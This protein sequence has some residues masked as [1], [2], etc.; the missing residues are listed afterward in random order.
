MYTEGEMIKMVRSLTTPTNT[1]EDHVAALE[2]IHTILGI[3][4]KPDY[5]RTYNAGHVA[6]VASWIDLM[7]SRNHHGIVELATLALNGYEL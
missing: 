1:T 2:I 3:T 5:Y 7:S 6:L 4:L